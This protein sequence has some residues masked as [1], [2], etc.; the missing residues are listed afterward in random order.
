MSKLAF[1][2]PGQGAQYIGMGKDFYDEIPECR[3][4]YDL[5]GQTTGIDVKELCFL[6]NS[7]INI[8]EFT[9]IAMLTTEVAMLE[10]VLA[11]GIVPDY[12]AGLSLGEYGALVASGVM[13]KKD[14][15]GVIRQRGIIMQEAVPN[16]GAMS[17]VLG[18]DAEYIEEICAKTDGVVTIAN[19]NCPGQIVITGE[20]KAVAAAGKSMLEQG[21]RKVIPLNVSGPFHSPMLQEAGNKLG[22]ILQGV[23]LNHFDIPYVSNLTADYVFA[24]DEVKPL[25]IRQVASPVR[26]QQSIERLISDGVTIFAEIGPGKTLTG[27][28]KKIN[29]EVKTINIEKTEDIKKAVEEI[30]C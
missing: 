1:V 21:A 26:W 10:A 29:K 8:T 19:Y 2:F 23:E 30:K 7:R 28:I 22:D 11:A 3:Q 25:L 12:T 27:F 6:D 13:E 18:M 4:V 16:G 24:K 5:A 14:A 15:F 20:E 9:Q 17:A